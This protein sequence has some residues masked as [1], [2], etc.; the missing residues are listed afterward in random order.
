MRLLRIPWREL[1][2]SVGK[3]LFVILAVAVGVGAFTGVQGFSNTFRGMLLSEART[4]MAADLMVRAFE[5]ASPDQLAVLESLQQQG[6]ELTRITETVSMM[7][8]EKEPT[9]V[10]VAVKAVDPKVYPFY[11]ELRLE[12]EG[13]LADALGPDSIGVSD[14]LVLRLQAGI[15]DKVKL[16]SAEYRIATVVKLEPDRMTGSINVGPRVMMTREG[17]DRAELMQVGSRASQR[18]LFRMPR[19][20]IR[21]NEARAELKEAFPRA[22]ITDFRETHPRITRGLDR[23]TTFL[24]LVSLIALIVGALGVAMAMHSHLQQ[25]MDTIAVMKCLGARSSQIIG[26]YLAQTLWLGLAGGLL[27]VALG[28]AVQSVFPTLIERYFQLRPD[29]SFDLASAVQGLL[30]G[31]LA[32][33]LFTLPPLLGIR[34]VR[35]AVIF[36]RD[37]VEVRSGWRERWLRL[38]ASTITGGVILLGIGLLS[39]WLAN[40][41]LE[42]SIV[43]SLFFLGGLVVSLSLLSV[44]AVSLLR[45][46]RWTL[47]RAPRTLPTSLRHGMANLYRPG[48]HAEA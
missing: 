26:I 48:N 30:I 27:G 33:L 22:L 36:R 11:G 37:M 45:L 46:L 8:S 34:D 23:A 6:A 14:D 29:Q 38:R 10:L 5:D 24:S 12:P 13:K 44:V 41:D 43:T 4:L 31:V 2:S 40:D 42:D 19:E 7:S 39:A 28:S 47:R 15:G 32:T 16:G 20:G 25:R 3:F 21:I 35:P 9:P 18:F 17:L 1:R